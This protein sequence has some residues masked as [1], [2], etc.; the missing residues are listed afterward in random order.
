MNSI[1]RK[2]HNL[3]EWDQ[4]NRF[5]LIR[6]LG[7][8]IIASVWLRGVFRT[9]SLTL[10]TM[11]KYVRMELLELMKAALCGCS[12]IYSCVEIIKVCHLCIL[13]VVSTFNLND[14]T[15]DCQTSVIYWWIKFN[16]EDKADNEEAKYKNELPAKLL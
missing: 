2:L 7:V 13:W 11:L 4:F 5:T 15:N 9:V 12:Q 16:R 8:M 1:R 3:T 14:I 6:M 10:P